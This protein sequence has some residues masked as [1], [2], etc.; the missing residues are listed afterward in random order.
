MNC[1]DIEGNGR[2]LISIY[3]PGIRLDGLRKTT[4]NLRIVGLRAE[5]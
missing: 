1:K 4:E 5:I 3:Y 2:G